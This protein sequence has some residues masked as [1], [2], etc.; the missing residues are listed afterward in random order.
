MSTDAKS[1]ANPAVVGLAG[2]GGTTLLLQFHNFDLCGAGPVFW[3][4][5]FF[6]GL[7][8]FIAGF[9]EFNTGNN[10][11]FAAF[12]SYGAFWMALAGILAGANYGMFGIDTTDIGWFLVIFTILTAIFFIGAMK[13]SGA[14][15][16]L[17]LTLLIGFILLD[18]SHLGGPEVFTKVAAADLTIC[19]ISAW[20]LMAH[21]IL[22]PLGIELPI[23]KAWLR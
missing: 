12:C 15:S 20:Y 11:G 7:M 21:V 8:Q 17:F 1:L 6:G 10:F 4:A 18:V 9:K 14:L 23:G 2:F 3:C 22:L 5:V 16:I 13:Q 19:A